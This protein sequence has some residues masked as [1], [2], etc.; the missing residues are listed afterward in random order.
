M[1]EAFAARFS[2]NKKVM[3]ETELHWKKQRTWCSHMPVFDA[4]IVRIAM[5]AEKAARILT[6]LGIDL[7]RYAAESF[8]ANASINDMLPGEF[9]ELGMTEHNQPTWQND[10]EPVQLPRPVPMDND[11]GKP[12]YNQKTPKTPREQKIAALE[13]YNGLIKPPVVQAEMLAQPAP[14]A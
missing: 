9:L 14:A 11:D 13:I 12:V 5:D 1:N 8:L 7:D 2:N 4:S 10:P 6:P 3:E